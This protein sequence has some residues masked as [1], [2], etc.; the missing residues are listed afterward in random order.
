MPSLP[1]VKI[2]TN[3]L[4]WIYNAAKRIFSRG[5]RSV[6]AATMKAAR[7][8]YAI[9]MEKTIVNLT[10]RLMNREIGIQQWVLSFRQSLKRAYINQY[11]TGRGGLE[12]MTQ[13]DWGIMGSQLRRQYE[14]MNKFADEI[15]RG[16][17]TDAQIKARMKLYYQSSTQAH[18]RGKSEAHGFTL[19]AYPGDGQTQCRSN[20]KCEWTIEETETAWRCTWKLNPAEHCPDC[21]G[22]ASRWNPLVIPK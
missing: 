9:G 17:L 21:V 13:R 12:M 20:C 14:Y 16:N 19:P 10:T 5:G 7:D 6:S 11:V 4:N 15:V 1:I 2:M 3:I 18:E 22:N 8:N